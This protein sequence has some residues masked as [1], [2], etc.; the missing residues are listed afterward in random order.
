[1]YVDDFLLLAQTRRRQKRVMHAA[2]HSI[3]DVFR[4]LRANDPVGRKEPASTKK[5]LKCDAS[6]QTQKRVLGWDIDSVALTL[7]LPPHRL[8]RLREVLAWLQPPTKGLAVTR[9]H[10]LL[11]ELRSMSPALPGTRGLFSVLQEALR[12]SD[13]H[14]VRINQHVHGTAADFLYL[15]DSP[16]KRPTRLTELVHALHCTV[17]PLVTVYSIL[18]Y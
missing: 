2:L 6:W 12:K 7:N 1:M 18:Y 9:W 13:R 4:P 8:G 10:R 5:M 11:G 14:S 16:S 15:V 17:H 3:G